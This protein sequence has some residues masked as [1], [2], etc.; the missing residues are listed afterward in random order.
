MCNITLEYT[1][2]H[3]NILGQ[4]RPGNPFPDLPHAPAN[5]QLYDAV[6]VAVSQKIGRQV[7]N[8][9]PIVCESITLSARPQLLLLEFFTSITV[10]LLSCT[11]A[12]VQ[13][14]T[15]SLRFQ[16]DEIFYRIHI[17]NETRYRKQHKTKVYLFLDA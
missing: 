8:T 10:K 6:M 16:S 7:L 5:A 12:I 3:F 14:E 11:Y 2:T 1:A 17:F 9:G 13:K 15:F 4:T